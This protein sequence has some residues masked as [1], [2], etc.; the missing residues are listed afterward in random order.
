[1]T[2]ADDA[3]AALANVT[4]TET[5]LAER[6]QWPFWRHAL[7]GAAMGILLIGQTLDT[8]AS[9]AASGMV[10]V[11]ALLAKRYDETHDGVWVSGLRRGRTLWTAIPL[12]ILALAAVFFVRWGIERP[13]TAQPLFWL[14][15][16]VT[17][18]GSTAMSFLWQRQYRAELRG[19]AR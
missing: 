11:I 7:T 1:M 12:V 3:R 8:G 4:E 16:A 19:G 18:V 15:F 10:V 17:V 6:M 5:R 14:V 13:Q 2:D 9:V